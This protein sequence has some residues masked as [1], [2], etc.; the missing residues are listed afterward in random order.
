MS[1]WDRLRGELVDVIEW[2]DNSNDTLVWRFPRYRNEIKFGAMLTVRE[3][4]QAVFVNEGQI[5]E[6]F[7]PGMYK[8]ETANLPI[9]STLQGWPYGFESPFKAEVYFCSTRRFTDLKWGTRNP[10]MLRD[11]EFGAV[12]LRAFGT[13]AIRVSDPSTLVREIVGTDAHFTTDEISNQLRNIIVSRF[14]NVIGQSSIPVL[15]LAANYDELGKFISERIT[16]EI[17]AY[18]LDLVE[19][20]V[21]N[22]SLPPEVEQA[23]DKRTSMGVI[24]NL[25]D[26]VTFSTAD[27]MHAAASNPGAAGQGM[28]LGVGMV[29]AQQ[30]GNAVGGAVA[31]GGPPPLP[32]TQFYVALGGQQTGPY[33]L[34]QVRALADTGQLAAATLVWT[35]GMSEWQPASQVAALTALVGGGPP[36]LPQDE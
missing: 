32:A 2:T 19:Y 15:D 6:V 35:H 18:G 28:G 20:L 7:G 12:R 4:Q 30:V 8:L 23:L 11:K 22:I 17:N 34:E 26:Y 10:L 5:A 27:S 13:Y 33:A 29:M 9:L 31:T 3:S 36:P 25:R 14:A 1:L 21:E 16:P 24:G